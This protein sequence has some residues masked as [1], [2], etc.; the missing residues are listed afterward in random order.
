MGQV[1]FYMPTLDYVY[2]SCGWSYGFEC[3]ILRYCFN[4]C[5]GDELY[6]L[7]YSV[8][9]ALKLKVGKEWAFFFVLYIPAYHGHM[10]CIG[11]FNNWSVMWL[12]C[13][14]IVS[15]DLFWFGLSLEHQI[16]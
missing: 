11:S 3:F 8:N 14:W 10:A 16:H 13:V 9:P 7:S 1:L 6:I 15:S 5:Q 2:G 4:T 12:S